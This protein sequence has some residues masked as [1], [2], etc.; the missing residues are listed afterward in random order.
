MALNIALSLARIALAI[1]LDIRT[2]WIGIRRLNHIREYEYESCRKS[3][4]LLYLQV[5]QGRLLLYHRAG[6][7]IL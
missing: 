3:E 6:Q 4:I 7:F 2:G 1:M 5:L